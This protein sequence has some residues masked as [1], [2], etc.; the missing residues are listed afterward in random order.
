MASVLI[1]R[2][3]HRTSSVAAMKF[4]FNNKNT[5][6]FCDQWKDKQPWLRAW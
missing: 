3:R 5:K 4:N 1:A 2:P 6:P